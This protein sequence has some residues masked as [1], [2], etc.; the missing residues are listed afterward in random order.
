MTITTP[1]AQLVA[2]HLAGDPAALAGIYD[3]FADSLHDTAAAM[4]NNRD[5]AADVMQDVFLTA[6]SK[7]SQL[8]DPERLKPW[9][10][11]ILRNEVY[12]RTKQRK[13]TI[14]TDFSNDDMAAASGFDMTDERGLGADTDAVESTELAELV[15]GAARGL[16]ERDQLVLE[17]SVRQ[18]LDGQ[19][20]ADAL[21]VSA[22]QSYTLVHRMRERVEKS[23]GAFCVAKA[24]RKDCDE[25]DGILGQWDG[26][27][28]VLIRKRV[29]RHIER[30]ETCATSRRKFAP[31]ALF[32]GAPVFAAPA[33]LRDQVLGAAQMQSAALAAGGA[34]ATPYEFTAEGGFPRIVSAG[35]KLPAWIAP[36][37]AASL[38]LVAAGAGF[39]LLGNEAP[40]TVESAPIVSEQASTTTAAPPPTRATTTVAV[41]RPPSPATDAPV[42]PTTAPP[43]TQGPVI[44]VPPRVTNPPR[45][46]AAT[47]TT[48]PAPTAGQLA[49]SSTSVNLGGESTGSFTLSNPGGQPVSW[50]A[51]GTGPFVLSPA[52]GSLAPGSSTPITISVDRSNLAE[53]SGPSASVTFSGDGGQALP[54]AVSAS[55]DRP[56]TISNIDAPD[57]NCVRYVSGRGTQT[58][59]EFFISATITDE[60][61]GTATFTISG[62]GGRSGSGSAPF[63]SFW[64]GSANNFPDGD[65]IQASGTGTWNWTITATDGRGNSSSTSGS[66]SV[67]CA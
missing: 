62:P 58:L 18:G 64:F 42:P 63:G 26:E 31:L 47:T 21:G 2:G 43:T 40:D 15:R 66:T 22:N 55:V 44:A 12:R 54:L 23:L 19:D 20:L 45:G 32:A 39:W 52:A 4:L 28:T 5:D 61:S 60:S 59:W 57:V 37:A 1:D 51:S 49:G 50:S 25:L 27:F 35:R 56:P 6:A 46:P 9:L 38:L 7:M 3:R 14:A 16:D 17:L 34:P 36:T 41:T 30:C 65:T 67:T 24:G 8:R 10:F 33:A 29:A 48:P 13:R 11:A 53:G